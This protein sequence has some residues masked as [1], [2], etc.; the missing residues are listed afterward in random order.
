VF[1]RYKLSIE[2]NRSDH[3]NNIHHLFLSWCTLIWFFCAIVYSPPH[4]TKKSIYSVF[5]FCSSL[6][7]PSLTGFMWTDSSQ[8][9]KLF[10]SPFMWRFLH[11]NLIRFRPHQ[12]LPPWS[13][14][15][16]SPIASAVIPTVPSLA[17]CCRCALQVLRDLSAACDPIR[18]VRVLGFLAGIAV[19]WTQSIQDLLSSS[20]I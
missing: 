3:L 20:P 11:C 13:P 8:K 17:R 4:Q 7:T 9:K 14:Y 5:V 19:S 16:P 18:L 6:F 15:T 1:L 12:R 2:I 10:F